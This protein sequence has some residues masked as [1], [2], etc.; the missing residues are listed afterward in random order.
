VDPKYAT[1]LSHETAGMIV[2]A[3]GVVM[4]LFLDWCLRP[5]APEA[6]ADDAA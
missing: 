3:I 1:G 5:D 6:A 4:L 2:F